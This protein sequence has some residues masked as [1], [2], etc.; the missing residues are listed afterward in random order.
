M[1]YGTSNADDQLRARLTLADVAGKR[2]IRTRFGPPVTVREDNAAAA[3][4][5]MSR[6]AV[7]PRWLRYLPP[8]MSPVG[9]DRDDL[10]ESPG[11]AV[12]H[13]AELGVGDLVCEEKHMGSR[14]CLV[15][16][17]GPDTARRCFG[18]AGGRGAIYTRTGRAFFDDADT[19]EVLARVS[20]AAVP[21]MADLE[22]SWMILDAEILPWNIKGEGLIRAE[23]AEVSAAATDENDLLTDELAMAGQRGLDVAELT[24]RAG[25]RRRDLYAF[26]AAYG[27]YVVAGATLA[28]VRIAPFEVLAC[29]GGASGDRTLENRPR[30]WHLACAD[31]LVAADPEVFTTTRRITVD[32]RDPD[33][34]ARAES[35]WHERTSGGAEGMVVKAAANMVRDTTGRVLPVGL[36]VRGPD[37]L[38]IIYGPGYLD[39]LGRLRSRDLRH[40]RSMAAR[41]YRL[42]R[43]ALS[44]HVEGAP[45]WQV[46]ECVFGVLALESEPVDT[47]L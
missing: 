31:A 3:L 41:E 4:E 14:A 30:A 13:Y 24:G 46:H 34:V 25:S 35:W 11:A 37:Y 27:R 43:E 1:G 38:R 26:T 22:C 10:L 15:I 12:R 20:A 8:T 36:K 5:T 19:A 9:S 39:D 32:A 28:D 16:V 6:F 40:K 21:V 42:G 47:R 17:D 44:R 18:V 2:S 45:L 33:S 29:G 7:D 23:F